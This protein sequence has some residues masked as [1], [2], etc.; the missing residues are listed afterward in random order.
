MKLHNPSSCSNRTCSQKPAHGFT[1]PKF[2]SR[3]TIFLFIIA[4]ITYAH[5]FG[6]KMFQM[7]N[8]KLRVTQWARLTVENLADQIHGSYSVEVGNMTPRRFS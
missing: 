4:G 7:I 3:L 6:L 8:D 5:L 2:S 1:L